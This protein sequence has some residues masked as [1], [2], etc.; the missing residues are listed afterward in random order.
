M[1]DNKDLKI[2]R[3]A[4]TELK[5]PLWRDNLDD[6]INRFA[7]ESWTVQHLMA[8]MMQDQLDMRADNR[9]RTLIKRADFPQLKYF[10]DLLTDELPEDARTALPVLQSLEFVRDGRNV[11][12]Y[13]NPGTGKTHIAT[14]LGIEACAHGMTVMFTSVP[15]LITQ[16]KEARQERSLRSLENRFINYDLVICDEF[17][18]VSCDKEAGE[19]LFNH[20][21][22]RAGKK[23]VIITT[24]LAFNRW[25]EIIADK[26]LVTAMVDRLTHKAMLINMTGESFRMKETKKTSPKVTIITIKNL[27]FA[28]P[29]NWRTSRLE[30]GALLD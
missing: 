8:V 14:A 24:N 7:L 23:S 15:R 19:L 30:S 6:Y 9:R 1:E 22:L 25:N 28:S 18:Y 5:L 21:S 26:V 13:G 10:G 29:M 27:K 3:K 4:A 16:I 20:L 17:G 11:V 12:L 2:I